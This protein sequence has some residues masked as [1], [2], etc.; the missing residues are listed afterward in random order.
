M[1]NIEKYMATISRDDLEKVLDGEVTQ[2]PSFLLHS[3]KKSNWL[4]L[5]IKYGRAEIVKLL[6]DKVC[7]IAEDP[8][9]NY[10]K[11]SNQL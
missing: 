8:S 10:F 9:E 4:F 6:L 11:N 1:V 7:D 3:G 2:Q 5:A